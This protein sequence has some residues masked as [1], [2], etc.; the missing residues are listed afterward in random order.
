MGR[1]FRI[2]FLLS[3]LVLVSTQFGWA[4][5]TNVF[6]QGEGTPAWVSDFFKQDSEWS[7]DR[8]DPGES[9]VWDND[10][11][12]QP[13]FLAAANGGGGGS[14]GGPP[15]KPDGTI[16]LEAISKSMDNPL[17]SL[18][19][20]FTQNDTITLRGP[21]FQKTQ[22]MN[23][24]TLMPIMPVPLTKDWILVNRPIMSFINVARPDTSAIN[25]GSFPG[26]FPGGG[27]GFSGLPSSI[28]TTRVTEMGDFIMWHALAP[29]ELPDFLNGK[30]LWGV[31]PSI[32]YPTAT[33]STL[34]S[35]KWS[36]G[37][38]I[39]GMY[40]GQGVKV[41]G[42]VQHWVSFAGQSDR[43][44]V[45]KSNIQPIVYFDLGNL[46]QIGTSPNILVNWEAS[47]GNKLTLPIGAAVNKTLLLF[48][49]LPVRFEGAVYWSAVKP[50]GVGQDW[51]F[52]FNVIPV[53]PNPLKAMGIDAIF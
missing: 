1:T 43:P 31:G 7:F 20:L 53:I 10:Y 42:L 27:P 37:P 41:G 49:K 38:G 12:A 4:Q 50:D 36:A 19:I 35:Q 51:L 16:D 14:G 13:E 28:P 30:F 2:V 8:F 21:P 34:G 47:S 5:G 17:G 15:L 23:V 33:H 3:L 40:M 24:F 46:W 52:R 6:D 39:L 22:V 48:G 26:L 45:S 25:Q 44:D 11:F 29:R 9:G 32:I 18:W